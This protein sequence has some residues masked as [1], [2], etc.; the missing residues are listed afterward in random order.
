MHV[1]AGQHS[2]VCGFEIVDQHLMHRWSHC[3]KH[4]M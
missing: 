2:Q 4:H 1:S 3:K